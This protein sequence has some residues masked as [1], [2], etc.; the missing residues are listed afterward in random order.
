MKLASVHM[1]E[2]DNKRAL[3]CFEDAIKVDENDPDVY[4]HRGQ[5]T[6]TNILQFCGGFLTIVPLS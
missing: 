2:G 1:E 3:E 4:Y 6:L 5:G